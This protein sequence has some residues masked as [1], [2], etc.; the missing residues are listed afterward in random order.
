MNVV[1]TPCDH[2]PRWRRAPPSRQGYPANPIKLI[3]STS[4]GGV[5]RSRRPYPRRATSP[6]KTGAGGGDRQSLGARAANIAMDAVAKAAPRRLHARRRQYRQYRHQSLSDDAQCH[7]IP[8]TDLVPVGPIG[9][10]P[11]FLV[12]NSNVPRQDAARVS[13]P[14]P[15]RSRT[16]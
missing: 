14:M 11:L 8:L 13:S 5:N 15:K 16:R 12:M 6:A 9:T 10:V 1:R 3:V 2:G 4:A 7:T